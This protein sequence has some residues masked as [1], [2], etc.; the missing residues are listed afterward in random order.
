M[1]SYTHVRHSALQMIADGVVYYT[2]EFA[3]APMYYI[4]NGSPTAIN[5]AVAA[6]VREGEAEISSQVRRHGAS[7]KWGESPLVKL[8]S[9]GRDLKAFWDLKYGRP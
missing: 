5:A 8:T 2:Q 3:G 7:H 4:D 6:F 9:S 1:G